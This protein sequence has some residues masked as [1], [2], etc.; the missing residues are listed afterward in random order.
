MT[1]KTLD[2]WI[3]LSHKTAKNKSPE[4]QQEFYEAKVKKRQEVIQTPAESQ[5]EWM[6]KTGGGGGGIRGINWKLISK[7]RDWQQFAALYQK[8]NVARKVRILEFE[9][10]HK[11]LEAQ[12]PAIEPIDA[13]A[14]MD[15][16]L[17]ALVAQAPAAAAPTYSTVKEVLEAEGM[18]VG[19][20][21]DLVGNLEL[22]HSELRS[23]RKGDFAKYVD[24]LREPLA[25][26]DTLTLTAADHERLEEIQIS[27]R[28]AE[29]ARLKDV[30][31][32]GAEKVGHS[33]ALVADLGRI[34]QQVSA[35][36]FGTDAK[37]VQSLA[38][39]LASGSLELKP[40]DHRRL[41]YIYS[42][43]SV[44]R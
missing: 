13:V 23:N 19:P 10:I 2:K 35:A 34:A 9:K 24:G 1:P 14:E 21:D 40:T 32:A 43:L 16:A 17:P 18:V 37:Y 26:G 20:S 28:G 11:E 41:E 6:A 7:G 33:D 30:L 44:H 8:G 38:A 36:G 22:L 29:F 31:A 25:K 42:G 4:E 39:E 3:A 12:V 27:L 15:A 5:A